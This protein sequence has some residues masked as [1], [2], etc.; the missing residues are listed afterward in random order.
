MCTIRITFT[1]DSSFD[2]VNVE[3]L[4]QFIH[5]VPEWDLDFDDMVKIEV[6]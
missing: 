6:I 3:S 2:V 4:S 5:D 1:D